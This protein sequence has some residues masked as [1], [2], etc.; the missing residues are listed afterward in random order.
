MELLFRKIT[1]GDQNEVVN[2]FMETYRNEPWN[3]IWDKNIAQNKIDDF[4]KSNISENYCVTDVNTKII[5]I[6]LGR[7]QYY[8]DS[9]ELY[10]D[11]FFIDTNYQN[12]GIG[13]KFMEYIEE[14][15]KLKRYSC[16]ILLTEKSLPSEYFY[17]KI[18]FKTKDETI[19][20]YKE[21]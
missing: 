5:G 20:M 4:L 9:K 21:I 6:L 18:G 10:V 12:Q 1:L 19:F 3:E 16:I 2:L 7:R 15:M 14:E 17:S 11:E 8:I 13:K